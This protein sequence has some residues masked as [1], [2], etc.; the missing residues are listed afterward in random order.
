MV[1]NHLCP[2]WATPQPTDWGQHLA[3]QQF[4]AGQLR[5]SGP[6]VANHQPVHPCHRVMWVM[7]GLIS[8]HGRVEDILKKMKSCS[9]SRLNRLKLQR[10]ASKR[11]FTKST[12]KLNVKSHKKGGYILI[13]YVYYALVSFTV[14]LYV[15][16]STDA[17][18]KGWL[19]EQRLALI[20]TLQELTSRKV[21]VFVQFAI[22]I[23]FFV[24]VFCA[25][26]TTLQ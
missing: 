17:C 21:Y 6:T 1:P 11:Q 13:S 25:Y 9:T 5:P 23:R 14:I 4:F 18:K 7:P 15:V 2:K 24:H 8:L 16:V 10:S 19:H 22:H 20:L 3:L 26:I 12:R